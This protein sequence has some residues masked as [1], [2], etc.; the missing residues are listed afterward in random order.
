MAIDKSKWNTNVKVSQKTIDEI[1]K[2]GMSKALKTVAGASKASGMDASAKAW[3]EG[4]KRLYGANRVAAAIKASAPKSSSYPSPSSAGSN[5][6]NKP[7]PKYSSSYPSPSSAGRNSSGMGSTSPKVP[8]SG[9]AARVASKA[10][11]STPPRT[12]GPTIANPA[13]SAKSKPKSAP[14][15]AKPNKS[16]LTPSDSAAIAK[17]KA[18]WYAGKRNATTSAKKA[19]SKPKAKITSLAP[20]RQY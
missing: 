9:P 11:S 14:K 8:K 3:T 6:A 5:S 4:V 16:A 19:P 10:S 7:K 20:T 15:V 12:Y 17:A 18:D 13:A 1:K 2:M